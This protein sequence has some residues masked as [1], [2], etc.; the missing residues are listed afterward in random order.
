MSPL[1]SSISFIWVPCS[2]AEIHH[3][4]K[5]PR[6]HWMVC[7]STFQACI[8]IPSKMNDFLIL[9]RP[10]SEYQRNEKRWQIK[11][12]LIGVFTEYEFYNYWQFH[13]KLPV[14]PME[15]EIKAIYALS[16]EFESVL[17]LIVLNWQI[18]FD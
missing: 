12:K 4:Q 15:T 13:V 8:Y 11:L 16:I 18:L 10:N 7:K 17:V 3:A 5:S 9:R 6:R 2:D 1:S 14:F